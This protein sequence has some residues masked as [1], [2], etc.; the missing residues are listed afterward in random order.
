MV[1][2]VRV[3]FEPE[4]EVAEIPPLSLKLGTSGNAKTC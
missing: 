1:V 4:E 2:C 3:R